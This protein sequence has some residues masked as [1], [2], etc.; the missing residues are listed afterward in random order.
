MDHY[1]RV[2]LAYQIATLSYPSPEVLEVLLPL[3]F[4]RTLEL[5]LILRQSPRPVKSPLN[6]LRRAVEEGWIPETMPE[7]VNRRIQN[8]EEN[9]YIR[10]GFTPQEAVERA[11]Q[12][13]EY[14]QQFDK[15]E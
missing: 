5:L 9:F 3:P 11:R 13:R 8:Y 4:D 12:N 10:R 7:K 14:I 2:V 15:K 6:F 1:R